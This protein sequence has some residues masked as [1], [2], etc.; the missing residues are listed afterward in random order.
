MSWKGKAKGL[1]MACALRLNEL[2]YAER[3]AVEQLQGGISKRDIELPSHMSKR[4]KRK[5]IGRAMAYW[6]WRSETTTW[7][8]R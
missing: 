2:S 1:G 3:V 5:A 7:K 8:R 4:Q 6:A